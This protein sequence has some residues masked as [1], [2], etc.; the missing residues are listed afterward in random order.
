MSMSFDTAIL[1]VDD[2]AFFLKAC[3]TFVSE[4]FFQSGDTDSQSFDAQLTGIS[5]QIMTAAWPAAVK[6]DFTISA[7]F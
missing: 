4:T 7:K 1:C 6:N 5:N 2:V 3:S